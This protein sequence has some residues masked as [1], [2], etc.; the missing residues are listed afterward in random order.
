MP[1]TPPTTGSSSG[2]VHAD[3]ALIKAIMKNPENYYVNV[4]ATP[5][6]GPGALR[7]QLGK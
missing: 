4:H 6:F 5:S 1:L 7:G 3:R 2:C